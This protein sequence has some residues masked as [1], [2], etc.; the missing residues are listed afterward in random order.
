VI[1][2]HVQ[3]VI[4]ERFDHI[5][6]EHQL[7][8]IACPVLLVHGEQDQTVPLSDAHRLQALLRTG[9][10]LVVEADHD[11]RASMAPHAGRLVDFFCRHLEAIDGPCRND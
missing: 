4:G 11:L 3:E 2:E 9:E 6:P 8:H 5:A 7:A 10:L 1:L